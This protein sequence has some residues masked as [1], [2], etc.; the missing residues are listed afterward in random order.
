MGSYV[1]SDYL[2]KLLLPKRT[3]ENVVKFKDNISTNT[4][5]EE[6]SNSGSWSELIFA[7]DFI[8]LNQR[9]IKSAPADLTSSWSMNPIQIEETKESEKESEEKEASEEKEVSE[10]KEAPDYSYLDPENMDLDFEFQ[11][12][13][14]NSKIYTVYI[15]GYSMDMECEIPF[16]KFLMELYGETFDFPHFDFTCPAN[17]NNPSSFITWVWDS[18]T[19]K[20]KLVKAEGEE[21]KE[22]EEENKAH[23]YFLNECFKRIF[24]IVDLG[25]HSDPDAMKN[26]YKGYILSK[27]H[28]DKLYAFFDF[29]QLPLEKVEFKRSWG[30]V[31]EIMNHKKILGFAVEPKTIQ[32]FV[33]TP[34]VMQITDKSGFLLDIP[35]VLYLCK[36]ENEVYVN[37]YDES[38]E[39]EMSLHTIR[40]THPNFGRFYLFSL[41][42]LDFQGNQSLFKIER[43]A[44]FT[45]TPKYILKDLLQKD[46]K[47]SDD[48][49][50]N[51][52]SIY[53]Q[54]N[55]IP[56]WMIKSSDQFARL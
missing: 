19:G 28:P 36:R 13:S 29:G 41:T 31:D 53:F 15:C 34:G 2:A 24:G 54:E 5:T 7:K 20:Q 56:F 4:S 23:T 18:L 32:I 49:G 45:E 33:N 46:V 42:P 1:Q 40:T 14:D 8:N 12:C 17:V 37:V 22:G 16:L 39:D 10:E 50:Y 26:M 43:Y 52:G 47:L 44:G 11:A 35:Y 27:E 51:H 6:S 55:R 48:Y 9:R 38:G 21:E 25:D 3:S 30:L